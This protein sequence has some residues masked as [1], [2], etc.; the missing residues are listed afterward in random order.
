MRFNDFDLEYFGFCFIFDKC[1]VTEFWI[2]NLVILLLW[3]SY[4]YFG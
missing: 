2:M 4:A 1:Y 3:N